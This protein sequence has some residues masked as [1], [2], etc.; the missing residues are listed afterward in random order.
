MHRRALELVEEVAISSLALRS[1]RAAG[2][3]FTD[4]KEGSVAGDVAIC[5]AT[6]GQQLVTVCEA[7]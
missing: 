7:C 5:A 4:L 2:R 3:T 6:D 1:I